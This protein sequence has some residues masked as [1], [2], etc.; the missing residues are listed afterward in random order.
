MIEKNQGCKHMTCKNCTHEFCWLCGQNWRGHNEGL[1]TEL[2]AKGQKVE[3][4]AGEA[5]KNDFVK[6]QRYFI[7]YDIHRKAQAYAEKDLAEA[8][9]RMERLQVLKDSDFLGKEVEFIH[10]AIVTVV[11]ARRMLC[12]GYAWSFYLQ[13]TGTTFL[14]LRDMLQH[15][16]GL[17]EQLQG[18]VEKDLESLRD[19]QRRSTCIHLTKVTSSFCKKMTSF[20]LE[21]QPMPSP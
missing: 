3:V 19:Q 20:A 11:V 8:E 10:N 18:I 14:M 21:N 9:G 12:W 4:G 1:C 15:L 7:R 16:E 13:E 2:Q 5:D 6:Y 17:A